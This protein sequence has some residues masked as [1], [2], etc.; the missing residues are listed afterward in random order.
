[1]DQPRFTLAEPLGSLPGLGPARVK[2]LERLGLHTV[3]DL[4]THY[5]RRYEDR[6]EFDLFPNA[7]SDEPV[8]VCGVVVSTST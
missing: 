8:C 3:G 4:L 1:M 5:P 7:G 2:P 6:R